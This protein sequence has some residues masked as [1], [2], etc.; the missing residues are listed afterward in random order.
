[1]L[2]SKS[3][4]KMK[5][6]GKARAIGL[7]IRRDLLLLVQKLIKSRQNLKVLLHKQPKKISNKLIN[8]I[9]KNKTKKSLYLIKKAKK[10]PRKIPSFWNHQ[11]VK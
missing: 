5:I 11:V 4:I 9:K 3:S 7:K 2:D 1:M 10:N 6:K 8:L